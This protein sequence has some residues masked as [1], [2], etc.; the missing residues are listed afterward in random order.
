MSDFCY[1][2]CTEIEVDIPLSMS[3]LFLCP[4]SKWSHIL[5]YSSFCLCQKPFDF[6]LR[7][8]ILFSPRWWLGNVSLHLSATNRNWNNN[9]PD[10]RVRGCKEALCLSISIEAPRSVALGN[11][12]ASIYLGILNSIPEL[13][14]L[15]ETYKSV[16]YH[17]NPCWFAFPELHFHIYA[18]GLHWGKLLKEK[19]SL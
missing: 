18:S 3:K 11:S 15:A 9:T 5:F 6:L 2:W 10:P 7:M 19:A 4:T 12:C 17:I 13:S 8:L 16:P 1:G 14:C